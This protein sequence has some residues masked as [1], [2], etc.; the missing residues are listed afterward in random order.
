MEKRQPIFSQ[1]CL[2]GVDYEMHTCIQI[3]LNETITKPTV[4]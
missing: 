3:L 1:K 4:I 2:L